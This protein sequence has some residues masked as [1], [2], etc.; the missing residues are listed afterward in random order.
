LII[1]QFFSTLT[2]FVLF[3]SVSEV[4]SVKPSE[5]NSNGR[6][7]LPKG[8][9]LPS[10][11]TPTSTSTPASTNPVKP[12][13]NTTPPSN[14]TPL[15]QTLRQDV[16][17]L[18]NLLSDMQDH[19]S[20]AKHK[21]NSLL[22]RS[23]FPTPY[24][25]QNGGCSIPCNKWSQCPLGHLSCTNGQLCSTRCLSDGSCDVGQTCNVFVSC[26]RN[27][28]DG[29]GNCL[30]PNSCAD[31]LC[32]WQCTPYETACP[33]EHLC[34]S[35]I[36]NLL[37]DETSGKCPPAFKPPG[38]QPPSNGVL[39]E[40]IALASA[41]SSMISYLEELND[42][43]LSYNAYK[44]EY[45]IL[46]EALTQQVL[47]VVAYFAGCPGYYYAQFQ[48]IMQSYIADLRR[49]QS[50][51]KVSAVSSLD[52]QNSIPTQFLDKLGRTVNGQGK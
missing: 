29:F 26:P 52:S 22:A 41:Y 37:C 2:S 23:F 20:P 25:C 38:N 35:E 48:A 9:G 44:C 28:C 21:R 24:T 11:S 45:D 47:A 5:V 33:V 4:A 10:A 17:N 46:F 19:F 40:I 43:F 30:V 16:Q 1:M 13:V 15:A 51:G 12:P 8:T 31:A 32:N 34:N 39:C 27:L 7:P 42:C 49:N 36:C 50:P 6:Y 3:L 14:T 18:K